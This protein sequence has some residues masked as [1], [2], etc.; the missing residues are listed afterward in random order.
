MHNYDA[1]LH[2]TFNNSCNLNCSYCFSHIK[3]QE[4][5]GRLK[6]PA[7]FSRINLFGRRNKRSC[8]I[9]IPALKN[10]LARAGGVFN[11]SFTGGGEPFLIPNV[12]QACLEITRKHYV[13]FNTNLV[14]KKVREFACKV[15]PEKVVFFHAS[16]HIKELER[17]GLTGQYIDNFYLFRKHGF[18]IDASE[19][20]YPPLLDEADRYRSFFKENG[21]ELRFDPF[22]GE[23]EGRQYPGSYTQEELEIFNI[24]IDTHY[25]KGKLCNAGYNIG[26]VLEEDGNIS[27]CI[28]IRERIGNIYGRINFRDKLIRC[29]LDFCACPLSI[30][31][32]YLFKKAI[33]ESGGVRKFNSGRTYLFEVQAQ[34]ENKFTTSVKSFS[35]WSL[36]SQ[37]DLPPQV[38]HAQLAFKDGRYQECLKGIEG[39]LST[40]P[41]LDS[42]QKALCYIGLASC[43]VEESQR[44]SVLKQNYLNRAKAYFEDAAKELKSEDP[45][46]ISICSGLGYIYLQLKDEDRAAFYL[47]KG[48]QY[49][50]DKYQKELIDIYTNLGCLCFRQG[51][52]RQGVKYSLSS[53]KHTP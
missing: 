17:L 19:V 14:C 36:E 47:K 1:W 42:R 4:K 29:P 35:Q 2:W 23:Y 7:L 52:F 24:N 28:F 26:V 25:R 8:V 43:L 39:F 50:L 18:N 9:D 12:V 49:P 45:L 11:I 38:Q 44:A 10:T 53:L 48:L 6:G 13:G 27:P 31:D 30:C 46:N 34:L 32:P 3:L 22:F 33:E 16:L 15:N 41:A 40:N 20:G 5:P 21:I 37:G 51:A